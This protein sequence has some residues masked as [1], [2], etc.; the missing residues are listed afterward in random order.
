ML[1]TDTQNVVYVGKKKVKRDTVA[2]TGLV[3]A[4]FGDMHRVPHSSAIRLFRHPD[5]WVSE[6]VF[7]E[8]HKQ[9]TK[10]EDEIPET[11]TLQKQITPSA[12]VT[13]LS[14]VSASTAALQQGNGQEETRDQKNSTSDDEQEDDGNSNSFPDTST[15]SGN[16]EL[17]I[18]NALLS[19]DQSDAEH[20]SE[21]TGAPLIKAVRDAVGDA[22]ISVKEMNAAWAAIQAGTK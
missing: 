11:T 20:F 14:D 1:P 9:V 8:V 22:T 2:G 12:P 5:V 13:G 6:K 16:R 21:Q 3:W 17:A 19:L 18:K 7:N 4:G 15:A 10:T